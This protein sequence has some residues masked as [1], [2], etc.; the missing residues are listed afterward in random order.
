MTSSTTEVLDFMHTRPAGGAR[1]HMNMQLA[2]KLYS[3]KC[4][5]RRK[6]SYAAERGYIS[7]QE[8]V[9]RPAG[10]RFKNPVAEVI[11]TRTEFPSRCAHTTD[12]DR[13]CES[14]FAAFLPSPRCGRKGERRRSRQLSNETK[15]GVKVSFAAEAKASVAAAPP[16]VVS[17]GAVAGAA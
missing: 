7:R 14:N 1:N 11:Y 15:E 16:A 2:H 5:T 4:L 12:V 3:N 6:F 9:G 13:T 17:V 8:T 10:D